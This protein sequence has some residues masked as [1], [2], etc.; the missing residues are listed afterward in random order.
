MIIRSNSRKVI[1][2]PSSRLPSSMDQ[3]RITKIERP[4]LECLE[5]N[6][7]KWQEKAALGNLLRSGFQL[8]IN[9]VFMLD[10]MLKAEQSIAEL[11]SKSKTEATSVSTPESE[12]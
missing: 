4:W 9:N 3:I 12:L 2:A 11:N 8:I 7:V 1:S 6:K 5:E 10:A